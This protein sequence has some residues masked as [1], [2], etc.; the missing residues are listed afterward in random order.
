LFAVTDI[1]S[2]WAEAQSKFFA[3]G[4]VFDSIYQIP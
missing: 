2:G 3:E 1:V 4:G